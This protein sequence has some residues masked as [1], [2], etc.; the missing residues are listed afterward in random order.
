[1]IIA[2][3]E[4]GLEPGDEA[5]QAGVP[6]RRQQFGKPSGTVPVIHAHVPCQP[7]AAT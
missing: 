6:A 2:D 7:V 4:A 5:V 3:C 1:M